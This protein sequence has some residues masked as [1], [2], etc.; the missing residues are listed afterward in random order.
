[1]RSITVVSIVVFLFGFIVGAELFRGKAV[2]A[3]EATG[4]GTL[5]HQRVELV[6]DQKNG[7]LRVVIDGKPAAWFDADGLHVSFGLQY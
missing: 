6:S 2:E 3:R 4:A 7:R 5:T 1:M